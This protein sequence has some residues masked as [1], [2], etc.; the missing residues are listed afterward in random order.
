MVRTH[1]GLR[2]RGLCVSAAAAWALAGAFAADTASAAPAVRPI[3]S[4]IER[5]GRR[6]L[7]VDGQ[8]FL[9][10]GAQVNNSSNWPAML[11]YVWPAIERLH[12]NTVEVPIAWEQIEPR[13]AHFDFSF[14]DALLAQAREHQVRLVL[15]WFATWKNNGPNYAP[16]W[17]KLDNQRFPRVIDSHGQ[18]KGSLSPLA[19]TTLD[20][21]RT[22][23]VALMHH[24]R[25]V[26]PA[27][28]VVMMQV[29][30]ETGTYGS[31]RD[32]SPLAQRQFE[33]PVPGE[34]LAALPARTTNATPDWREAYGSDADEFFHAWF[35]ARFVGAVAAAGKAEYPLPM[36]VNAALRDPL[37][38][39]DPL[40]Y[41]SGG[42]THNVIDIW[43]AAA[44][45]IDLIGP[46]IYDP[47]YE[48]CMAV[49]QLYDRPD[50]ALF[51][52]EIGNRPLYARY[53]YAILGRHAIGYS[54]FGM[55][56]TGYSNYPLGAR[57]LDAQTIDAFALNY[58]VLAPMA[59]VW[60]RLAFEQ[61]TWGVS[62]QDQRAPQELELGRWH[63]S[64]AYDRWQFG[65]NGVHEERSVNPLG[66]DGGVLLA[67]LGTDEF[68]VIGRNARISFSAIGQPGIH[69]SLFDRVE[70][71]H[72][73]EQQQWV[74][75]RVWNGD[76]TD[77]GLNFVDAPKVL[78]V[79]LASY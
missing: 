19:R 38:A 4:I 43:K 1:E 25:A 2:S 34:L 47:H 57:V 52:P 18:I 14:V 23:F 45:S 37:R 29:E 67:R 33:A 36:Y 65:G 66:P 58:Q 6:A 76:Q 31:V 21:D 44:R 48:F 78:H 26:D 20:A 53:M 3:P 13:E 28:T 12:A 10:L 51:V 22:A 11:P 27:R 74:F 50:N 24:L 49:L 75:E 7:L 32:Y 8:P 60:A 41:S 16:G 77:Y 59:R 17:V 69:G 30:N 62:E 54:P 5:A 56:L 64:I 72:Y 68:L 70:E 42:P 35:I 9:M 46:D 40:T 39:Q 73:D 71:G 61:Q 15:L 63:A 55:D 79:R